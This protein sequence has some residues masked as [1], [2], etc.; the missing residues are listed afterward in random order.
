MRTRLLAPV[1]L[2]VAMLGAACA[3]RGTGGSGDRL[4]VVT[5]VSPIT[6]LVQNVGCDRI[7]VWGIVPEGTNSHTFEPAPSDARL[8][9]EADVVFMNGLHLE[10]PTRELAE[11]NVREGVPI[12]RLAE[13]TIGP[14]E[15]IFD[16]SFPRDQGDP[17]P[18]L[19]TNPIYAKRYAEIV[20]DELSRLD[21][22]HA[23]EYRA[24]Y[25]RLA[26][27]LDELDRLAREVTATVP[28]ENRK[29]LTYHD[30]FP[31]FAREY[32]WTVI[33]AIQ[34]SDF[35]EPTPAEVAR[36]IE[37]I[38][39]ERV[40]AIFGSE[41]FPSPVLEQIARETGA[42]YIDD[43]RDD[44]LPGENGDPDH[45]YV[46]LMAFDFRTFMGALGGD[47][48]AFDALPVENLCGE[49]TAHYRY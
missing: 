48:S 42:R 20:R 43:L 8:F 14:D 27:R 11:A 31:Y 28:P 6:N 45:S 26:A 13:R 5:T 3:Q 12:V 23:A 4:Q 2:A 30:S 17:N 29:L 9:A 21:P 49:A 36:L 44:D 1:G 37:Q 24:N 7:E 34:P 25:E 18:H 41:V 10:E 39:R 38:R 40:P 15:Y 35:S 19:W 32:G 46:G 22:E 33:G 16:F 47:A